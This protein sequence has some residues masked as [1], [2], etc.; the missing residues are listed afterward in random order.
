MSGGGPL[1]DPVYWTAMAV[2]GLS[3]RANWSLIMNITDLSVSQILKDH[4]SF[5]VESID[6]MYLNLILLVI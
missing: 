3:D 1:R 5:E 4:V 2:G 6:R